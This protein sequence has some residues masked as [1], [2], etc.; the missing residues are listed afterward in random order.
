MTY[1]YAAAERSRTQEL[2]AA[3][4]RETA[5]TTPVDDSEYH[6]IVPYD[7]NKHFVQR[8]E[9]WAKLEEELCTGRQG[10]A[11]GKRIVLVGMGGSG[12]TEIATRFAEANQRRFSSVLWF[13]AASWTTI[14]RSFHL[15]ANVL[16][17][18][19]ITPD[20]AQFFMEQW[21]AKHEGWL[22]VVNNLDDDMMVEKFEGEFLSGGMNGSMLFTSRNA[23]LKTRWTSIDVNEMTVAE[24]EELLTTIVGTDRVSDVPET[25]ELLNVLG[26][27]ALAIDQAGCYIQQTPLTT[28]EYLNYFKTHRD[29]LL[30]K[31]PS[32]SSGHPKRQVVSTTW[33]SRL[34]D[35]CKSIMDLRSYYFYSCFSTKIIY[36][37]ICWML[38]AATDFT[39]LKMAITLRYLLAD[40]GYH[41][42]YRLCSVTS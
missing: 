3:A 29:S 7:T 14:T 38:D 4:L 11:N 25:R 2:P 8:P 33:K 28:L 18:T 23:S 39:G 16:S 37:C 10:S 42:L 34:R 40:L 35:L 20:Y 24:G 30:S 41:Q 15:T 5:K 32:R 17:S 6:V 36:Q 1:E 22:V 9:I 13:D 21:L 12:K 27:L 31:H 26:N 19:T